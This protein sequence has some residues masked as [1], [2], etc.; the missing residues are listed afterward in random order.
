MIFSMNFR[1]YLC[2]FEQKAYC[3]VEQLKNLYLNNL[4]PCY[5]GANPNLENSFFIGD[6]KSENVFLMAD[7]REKAQ[8]KK[9][10][11]KSFRV[12]KSKVIIDN[13]GKKR[14]HKSRNGSRR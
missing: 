4:I 3:F 12:G 11:T 8:K 9:K 1:D 5:V 13:H 7:S 10:E 2:N 14:V 6:L